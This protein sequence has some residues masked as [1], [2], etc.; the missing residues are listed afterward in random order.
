MVSGVRKAVLA[1]NIRELNALYT[2]LNECGLQ[3]KFHHLVYYS[4]S[5]LKLGPIAQSVYCSSLFVVVY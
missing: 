3:P 2:E 1:Q 4:N 5:L